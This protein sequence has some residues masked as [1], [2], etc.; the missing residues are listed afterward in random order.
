MNDLLTPTMLKWNQVIMRHSMRRLILF[1]KQNNHSL[2][3]LNTLFRLHYRGSCGVTDLGEEMGVSIAAASQLLDKM[4]QQGLADRTEDPSDRRNKHIRLTDAGQ[5]LAQ[6]AL[7]ARQGWMQ[8]LVD[9][10]NPAQQIQVENALRLLIEKS[11]ILDQPMAE[12]THK[13]TL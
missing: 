13:G 11:I 6:Q 12:T 3:L 8:P 9:E 10:L 2:A 5:E 1:A 7:E 4:V